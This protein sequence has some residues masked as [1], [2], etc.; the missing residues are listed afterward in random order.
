MIFVQELKELLINLVRENKELQNIYLELKGQILKILI[1]NL[2][3]YETRSAGEILEM[4]NSL[5]ENC[6]DENFDGEKIRTFQ[7]NSVY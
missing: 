4:I 2:P 6:E 3:L 7:Q 1:P 5:K